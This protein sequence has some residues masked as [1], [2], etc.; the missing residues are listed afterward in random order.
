M[1]CAKS[2]QGKTIQAKDGPIGHVQDVYF[3]D[4]EWKIR[5][6]A[7][8]TGRWLPGKTVLLA[9]QTITRYEH[10]NS[11]VPV[12][13]TKDE[14]KSSTSLEAEKPGNP[15][16]C[17]THEVLGYSLRATDGDIG[18]LEDFVIHDEDNSIRFLIIKIETL[19]AAKKILIRPG[20]IIGI[21]RSAKKLIA[22]LSC[23]DVETSPTCEHSG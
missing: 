20:S 23:H 17:C 22:N 13:L 18:R 12:S 9:S 16:L 19:M 1:I 6:V 14:V 11:G 4:L 7:V 5:Y 15:H 3:D 21:D 8:K 2:F 10:G